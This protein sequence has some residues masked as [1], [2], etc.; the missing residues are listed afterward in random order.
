MYCNIASSLF[1]KGSINK[2]LKPLL[3]FFFF[4]LD[5]VVL[6]CVFLLLAITL[7]ANGSSMVG[8]VVKSEGSQSLWNFK[9][10]T[11][12]TGLIGLFCGIRN[13]EK[14]KEQIGKV[15][16]FG[17]RMRKA[18]SNHLVPCFEFF[19]LCFVVLAI[20]TEHCIVSKHMTVPEA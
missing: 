7:S 10:N 14:I 12:R 13:R 1:L 19:L 6:I 8:K 16:F 2:T 3:F 15:S 11:V 18:S 17:V 20:F 4:F 9:S 5:V